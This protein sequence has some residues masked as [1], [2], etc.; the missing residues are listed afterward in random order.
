[1]DG[2]IKIVETLTTSTPSVD[3][4]VLFSFKKK[5]VGVRETAHAAHDAE[6]VVGHGVH[7][8]LTGA[9]DTLEVKSDVV[10]AREV[11]GAGRLVGLGVQG[12]GVAIHVL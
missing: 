11:A 7:K 4:F 10:Q 6:D 5:L 9:L 2:P 12:E 1:M 8:H 3:Y